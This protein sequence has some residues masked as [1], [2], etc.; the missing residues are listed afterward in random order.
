MLIKIDV[1]FSCY[2]FWFFFIVYVDIIKVD[3]L[4]KKVKI[5]CFVIII[6]SKLDKII[7]V[8]NVIWGQ[9]CN[10][11][12]FVFCFFDKNNFYFLSICYIGEGFSYFT[13]KVRY[14]FKVFYDNYLDDYDWFLKVDDDIYLVMENF[15]YVLFYYDF[16]K[17]GYLGYYFQKF[18]Y[19]GYVLGGVGYVVSRKGVKDLVEKG[20]QMDEE[21][22][23]KDG[24]IEDKYIG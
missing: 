21:R 2:L 12:L 6:L 7:L 23:K 20:F 19:Q 11:V 1:L 14:V 9:R 8:V 22:C 24:E 17:F 18:M 3:E 16:N 15:R 5:L 4:F 13:V 10:R